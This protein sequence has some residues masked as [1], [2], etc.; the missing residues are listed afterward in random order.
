[1]H[2]TPLIKTLALSAALS[3]TLIVAPG[4]ASAQNNYPSRPVT[5]IVP[6]P[7][8]RSAWWTAQRTGQGS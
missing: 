3:T 2:F 8:P 7:A 6:A 1:M 5:I 4:L